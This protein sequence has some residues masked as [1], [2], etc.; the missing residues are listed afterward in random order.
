MQGKN[1]NNFAAALDV[2][3]EISSSNP[4]HVLYDKYGWIA[5]GRITEAEA[6]KSLAEFRDNL[7]KWKNENRWQ[8]N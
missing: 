4:L 6:A 8:S 2:V 7:K 1:Q 5:T 3:A